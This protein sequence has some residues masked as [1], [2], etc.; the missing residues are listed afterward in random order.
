[1]RWRP[2]YLSCNAWS[3]SI[4]C[5]GGPREVGTF[6]GRLFNRGKTGRRRQCRIADRGD[7]LFAEAAMEAQ[8]PE[9][10]Q[11]LFEVRRCLPH[12]LLLRVGDLEVEAD[13]EVFARF[14]SRPV[15]RRASR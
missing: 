13:V 2:G 3:R 14:D 9:H 7:L 6:R 12:R 4:R 8:R 15:R 5:S 11:V 10:L 1:M